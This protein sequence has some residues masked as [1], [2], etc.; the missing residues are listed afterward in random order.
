MKKILVLCFLSTLIAC[1]EQESET[2]SAL[3]ST[4]ASSGNEIPT[5]KEVSY[6]SP[7]AQLDS[8][9]L[10]ANQSVIGINVIDSTIIDEKQYQLEL[11][12]A[13][14]V[15]SGL[16]GKLSEFVYFSATRETARDMLP[17]I[18]E[19]TNNSQYDTYNKEVQYWKY[20]LEGTFYVIPKPVGNYDELPLVKKII[21]INAY[22]NEDRTELL[23][24]CI[25][26]L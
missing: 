1:G 21:P 8:Y 9:F 23:D 11:L 17:R 26:Q 18:Q 4:I 12:N 5:P 15:A 22:Y 10:T 7:I 16:P 6:A 14:F 20:T 3:S 2:K 25:K 19:Y 24:V 13:L